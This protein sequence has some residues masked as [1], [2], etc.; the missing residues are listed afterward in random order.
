ML[1]GAKLLMAEIDMR[2]GGGAE[3]A[4]ASG[5]LVLVYG[6]L[7]VPAVGVAPAA[8]APKPPKPPAA[9]WVV[10]PKGEAAAGVPK[11]LPV[12]DAPDAGQQT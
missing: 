10:A 11:R 1:G 7:R 9:G 2:N 5:S 8:G 6:T 3:P 4:G 12:V